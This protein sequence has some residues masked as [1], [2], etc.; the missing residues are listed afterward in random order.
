MA[1]Q[2]EGSFKGLF[3]IRFSIYRMLIDLMMIVDSQSQ[4]KM[5]KHL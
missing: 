1:S 5:I 2:N 3:E 4:E